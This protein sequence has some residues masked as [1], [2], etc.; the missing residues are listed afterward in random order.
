MICIGY[1][2]EVME[3]MAQY[4][5]VSEYSYDDESIAMTD[6]LAEEELR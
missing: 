4:D 6:A 5:Q 1:H 3:E 2:H